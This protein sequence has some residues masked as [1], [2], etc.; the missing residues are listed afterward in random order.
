MLDEFIA[1]FTY[2]ESS[3]RFQ[4]SSDRSIQINDEKTAI[5]KTG[6]SWSTVSIA[7]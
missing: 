6:S 2:V 3:F 1:P 7:Q 4:D 5:R